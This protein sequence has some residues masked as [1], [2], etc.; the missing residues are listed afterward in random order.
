MALRHAVPKTPPGSLLP[1][2]LPLNKSRSLPTHSESTLP[3]PLIPLHFNSCT[4]NAYTK[5]Q[6][7]GPTSTPKVWQLVTNH[8][9]FLRAR[10]KVR[11]PNPLCALLHDFWTIR[12]GGHPFPLVQSFL[13][14][15]LRA[16]NDH[17]SP[18]TP[19]WSP[20]TVAPQ[21][22]KCQNHGSCL[23]L[24]NNTARK[25]IRSARCLIY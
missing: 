7:G 19:H 8:S 16:F 20:G 3:Q 21:P 11:N 1:P 24:R 9:L 23:C 5:I 25:H 13:A 15:A 18:D 2:W 6:G 14:V 22:A 4:R 17:G 10:T 12:R